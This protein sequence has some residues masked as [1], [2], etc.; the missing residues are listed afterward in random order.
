MKI[1][2]AIFFLFSTSFIASDGE[3]LSEENCASCHEIKAL[4]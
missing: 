2:V 4:I 1:Y 3:V